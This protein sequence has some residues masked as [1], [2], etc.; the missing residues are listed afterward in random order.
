MNY[1]IIKILDNQKNIIGFKS[2]GLKNRFG[3]ELRINLNINKNVVKQLFDE[4]SKLEKIPN[5]ISNITN[6][7]LYIIEQAEEYLILFPDEKGL[8]PQDKNCSALY[9]NQL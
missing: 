8:Y 1:L 7:N 9:K 4:I 2:D 6:V 3:K 5:I